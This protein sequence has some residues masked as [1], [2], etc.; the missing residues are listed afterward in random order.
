MF[1]DFLHFDSEGTQALSL[2]PVGL[3]EVTFRAKSAFRFRFVPKTTSPLQ[4]QAF[5][6]R[7]A[8]WL[9]LLRGVERQPERE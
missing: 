2:I 6:I 9:Q 1:V 4:I 7:K 8:R 5:F 3:F